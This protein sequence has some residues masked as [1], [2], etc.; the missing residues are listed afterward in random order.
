MNKSLRSLIVTKGNVVYLETYF[1]SLQIMNVLKLKYTEPTK[2]HDGGG[3]AT[4]PNRV[5]EPDANAFSHYSS[6]LF[7]MK[8]LLL[9]LEEDEGVDDLQAAGKINETFRN[10]GLSDLLD[11]NHLGNADDSSSKRRKGN[12]SRYVQHGYLRKTRLSVELQPSLLLHDIMEELDLA[13]MTRAISDDEDGD[14]EEPER[15]AAKQGPP[16]ARSDDYLLPRIET[17]FAA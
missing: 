11:I 1:P 4:K 17:L 13:E 7:R 3:S 2:Q 12:T 14:E 8:A 15:K 5:G 9:C 6:N 16:S 10:A